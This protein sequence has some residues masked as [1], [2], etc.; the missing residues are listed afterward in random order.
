M[1]LLDPDGAKERGDLVGMA[2]GRI[3]PGRGVALA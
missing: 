1:P 3:S 2:V